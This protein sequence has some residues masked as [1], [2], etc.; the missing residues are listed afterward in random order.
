MAIR[1]MFVGVLF[2]AAVAGCVVI[3]RLLNGS[4]EEVL[5]GAI[6]TC[7]AVPALAWVLGKVLQ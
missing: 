1:A 2:V 6:A 5:M 4:T 3:S 7:V